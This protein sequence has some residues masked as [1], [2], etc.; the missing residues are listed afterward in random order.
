MAYLNH[1][2]LLAWRKAYYLKNREHINRRN[3]ENYEK[4]KDHFQKV[5]QEWYK[6]NIGRHKIRMRNN[7]LLRKFGITSEVYDAMLKKQNGKCAICGTEPSKRALVVDHCHKK[8][9]IRGLLCAPCN[10]AIGFMRDDLTT[11]LNIKQYLWPSE[12]INALR[13]AA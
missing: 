9:R 2:E 6:R 5:R 8:N 13:R 10:S 3:K 12:A 1:E 7:H 11:W 4:R